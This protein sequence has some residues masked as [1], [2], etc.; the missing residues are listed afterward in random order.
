MTRRPRVH[1]FS[2]SQDGLEERF[3]VEVVPGRAEV[4]HLSSVVAA[5]DVTP[6]G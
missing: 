2:V 6:G 4:A 3:A 5:A 1:T